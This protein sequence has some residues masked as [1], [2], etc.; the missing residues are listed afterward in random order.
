MAKFLKKLFFR[1]LPL[2]L[3]LAIAAFFLD[4]AFVRYYKLEPVSP[5]AKAA[6]NF[7]NLVKNNDSLSN[8]EFS[9]IFGPLAAEENAKIS[10][11]K[12]SE[13]FRLFKAGLESL[14]APGDAEIYIYAASARVKNA[15]LPLPAERTYDVRAFIVLRGALETEAG[16]L[17]KP[18]P[19]ISIAIRSG[20]PDLPVQFMK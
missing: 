14:G 2:L 4:R 9:K 11:G 17:A 3:A 19:T 13:L 1:W 8:E 18:A 10:K 12:T 16:E 5:E 20:K 7:Y 6:L 15:N